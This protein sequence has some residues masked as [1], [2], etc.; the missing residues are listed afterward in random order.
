[1][2]LV[3]GLGNPGPRYAAT[4]HN[5]GFRIVELWAGLRG[6]DVDELRLGGRFGRGLLRQEGADPLE[7]GVLEPLASMNRS[8]PPVAGAVREL[9]VEDPAEDLLL[10]LDDVD[11][12]FGRLRLRPS[13]SAGGH[14]GLESV[15]EALGRSD[16]P[17]LRFGV[18]RPE[19]EMETADWVL[20]P[21]APDEQARLPRH[22]EAAAAALDAALREGVRT[23]MNH[24]NR[25]PDSDDADPLQ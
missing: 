22:L 2:K 7:V 17:R 23:A 16:L 4:R 10:V 25:A 9:P 8:G 12:P 21:F 24:V 1:V 14:R 15:I 3:V 19:V 11:L 13:G 5:A 6:I 18:G 20:E